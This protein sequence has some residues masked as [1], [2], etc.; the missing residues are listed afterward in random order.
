ML[1]RIICRITEWHIELDRDVSEYE[2][3]EELMEEL[4]QLLGDIKGLEI[5]VGGGRVVIARQ[6]MYY[7]VGT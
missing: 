4:Y 6:V 5:E 3:A 2:D 1:M 7:G